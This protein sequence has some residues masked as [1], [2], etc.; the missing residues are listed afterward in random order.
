MA[1]FLN[2]EVQHRWIRHYLVIISLLIGHY[3]TTNVQQPNITLPN[4]YYK[5]ILHTAK[6]LADLSKNLYRFMKCFY[7]SLMLTFG[8]AQSINN[9]YWFWEESGRL[10][11]WPIPQ[12]HSWHVFILTDHKQFEIH[13]H[14]RHFQNVGT[15]CCSQYM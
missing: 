3:Y 5:L 10:K 9:F 7:K 8:T 15:Y 12:F 6:G 11:K 1:S 13:V 4:I 2:L 14:H